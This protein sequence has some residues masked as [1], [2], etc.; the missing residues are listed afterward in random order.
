MARRPNPHRASAGIPHGQLVSRGENRMAE[1]VH[2]AS[3]SEGPPQPRGVRQK[4][5]TQ[6]SHGGAETLSF[7]SPSTAFPGQSQDAE[8]EARTRTASNMREGMSACVFTCCATAS[9]VAV[10]CNGPKSPG[11][12]RVLKSRL[13]QEV[14]PHAPPRTSTEDPRVSRAGGTNTG[15]QHCEA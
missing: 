15:G 7:R 3:F 4:D 14:L 8:G 9:Q 6:V 5:F 2:T 10:I 12:R 13:T 1:R 11:G